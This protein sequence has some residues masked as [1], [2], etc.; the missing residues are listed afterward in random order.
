MNSRCA[1]RDQH[2]GSRAA[3]RCARTA[4]RTERRRQLLVHRGL[5]RAPDLR[6]DQLAKGIKKSERAQQIEPVSLGAFLRV[7]LS[8]GRMVVINLL[9]RKNAPFLFSTP[10]GTRP[11]V[12][13]SDSST[14]RRD[15]T[16]GIVAIRA[17][18]QSGIVPRTASGRTPWWGRSGVDGEGAADGLLPLDHLG[19]R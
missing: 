17:A 14:L 7:A 9:H 8:G 1:S 16:R 11:T 18:V 4:P 10:I 12:A 15:P 6:V 5:D 3:R 13:A 2:C 19:E